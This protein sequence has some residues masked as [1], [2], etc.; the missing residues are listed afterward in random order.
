MSLTEIVQAE[1]K[2][3]SSDLCLFDFDPVTSLPPFRGWMTHKLPE[4]K[5]TQGGGVCLGNHAWHVEFEVDPRDS[6]SESLPVRI[7]LCPGVTVPNDMQNMQVA[8]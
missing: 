4:Q 7:P 1:K 6:E 2:E 5:H 8:N 3:L